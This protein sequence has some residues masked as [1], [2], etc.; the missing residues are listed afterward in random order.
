MTDLLYQTYINKFYALGAGLILMFSMTIIF[1]IVLLSAITRVHSI[2][3]AHTKEQ[4][5]FNKLLSDFFY[6][7]NEERKNENQRIDKKIEKI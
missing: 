3:I 1:I 7:E 6:L 5:E 2:L 4:N